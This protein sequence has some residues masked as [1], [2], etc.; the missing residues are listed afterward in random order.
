LS[1]LLTPLNEKEPDLTRRSLLKAGM[2][3]GIAA[4]SPLSALAA[5]F[6][7]Q[8]RRL[9]LYR[10]DTKEQADVVYWEKGQLNYAGYYQACQLL[11]DI[12]QNQAVQMDTTLFDVLCGVQGWYR[13]YG[14]DSPLLVNSGFRT[15]KTNNSLLSEGAARNS[16]HL[17]GKA[18]DIRMPNV[19]AR[20]LGQVGLYFRQ[21]GVG[22]YETRNFV[23]LD[24][25]RL[26]VWRG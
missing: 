17:Y 16:M 5:D 1:T 21:G 4:A 22:F 13:A 11:R 26:R 25:G 14:F 6:W 12:H 2:I 9:R 24:T 19:P 7:D 15:L 23:H 3:L 8:P 10:P 20:H 18:A